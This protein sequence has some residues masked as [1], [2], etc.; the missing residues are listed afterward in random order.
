M[1]S[2]GFNESELNGTKTPVSPPQQQPPQA[3]V[4][5]PQYIDLLDLLQSLIDVK[6]SF[7]SS[8]GIYKRDLFDVKHQV[9]TEDNDLLN[10]ILILNQ[11]DLTK[12]LYE[13]G[14]KV[15]ECCYDLVDAL[16]ISN[17]FFATTSTI[18]EIGSGTSL[19]S[20]YI[21]KEK[22]QSQ[23]KHPLTLI[24][25]D[26]NYDVLRLVT[27]PNILVNW[28]AMANP[29]LDT[30]DPVLTITPDIVSQFTQTLNSLN[31]TLKFISGSWSSDFISLLPP[32]DLILSSETIYSPETMPLLANII[33]DLLRH[34]NSKAL[35]AA[36]D[37]YFGVG[38]SVIDF[39]TYISTHSHIPISIHPISSHL[40]RSIVKLG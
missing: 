15:W 35:V 1:F 12:N 18:I 5:V 25:T 23:N 10:H 16:T 39:T 2:F 9:M 37:Y 26:F 34:P 20:C 40:K 3:N 4:V 31:I 29:H 17:T 11:S 19:P 21:F 38:G 27:L 14:F 24:M 36:K 32:I 33:I 28:F 13:G 30:T 22:L 6:I 8:H 7:S